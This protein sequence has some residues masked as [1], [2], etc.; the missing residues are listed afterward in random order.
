VRTN[1]CHACKK[2]LVPG[3]DS[4]P[5]VAVATPPGPGLGSSS[6]APS[7]STLPLL[8][9]R[10][11]RSYS[12]LSDANPS[13]V[14]AIR[15]SVP[16]PASQNN[17]PSVSVPPEPAA[18]L[19]LTT[20]EMSNPTTV[21]ISPTTNPC[22]D[23]QPTVSPKPK[24]G[25]AEWSVVYNSEVE[26]SLNVTLDRVVTYES[27]VY[28]TRFSPDGSRLA[29]GLKNSAGTYIYDMTRGENSW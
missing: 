7:T 6:T 19:N 24:S 4:A 15:S 28:C 13:N 1:I 22:S 10:K 25:V 8:Q 26:K 12:P 5:A 3:N 27:T 9:R 18:V 29:V 20:S 17:N 16:K 2:N 11:P 23:E 14:P 21:T